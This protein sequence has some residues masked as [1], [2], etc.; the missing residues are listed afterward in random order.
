M[1]AQF[2]GWLMVKICSQ[3]EHKTYSEVFS[4]LTTNMSINVNLIMLETNKNQYSDKI[5]N[6]K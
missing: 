5:I 4:N 3:G 6:K 2:A 1:L